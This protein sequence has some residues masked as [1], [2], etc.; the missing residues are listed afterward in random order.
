MSSDSKADAAFKANGERM[1][2]L[3][4]L[5]EWKFFNDASKL[6]S[7]GHM[8]TLHESVLRTVPNGIEWY[9]PQTS[10]S[11]TLVD[12]SI[13]GSCVLIGFDQVSNIKV[14]DTAYVLCQNVNN[15]QSTYSHVWVLPNAHHKDVKSKY[16]VV[17]Y[18]PDVMTVKHTSLNGKKFINEGAKVELKDSHINGDLVNVNG[19]IQH[20]NLK[21]DGNVISTGKNASIVSKTGIPIQVGG[22]VINLVSG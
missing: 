6:T 15:V 13:T 16:D 9:C 7:V 19:Q 22:T 20:D 10:G 14:E 11:T 4:V 5:R 17:V 3:G 18:A 12:K 21:V 2:K 8:A 1:R